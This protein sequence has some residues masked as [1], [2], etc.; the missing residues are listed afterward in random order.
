VVPSTR[1]G[2]PDVGSRGSHFEDSHSLVRSTGR[3]DARGDG[4]RGRLVI[5]QKLANDLHEPTTS[6]EQ[7]AADFVSQL[8]RMDPGISYLIS[9]IEEEPALR[10][11][12]DAR[13]FIESIEQLAG[14][15][16]GA[17]GEVSVL[18]TAVQ[19]LGEISNRLRP[20]TRRMSTVLRRISDS[21][22]T[23]QE[24]DRRLTS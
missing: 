11:E 15:A 9:Q 8:A 16:E 7:L 18:A 17:L 5:A 14:A 12:D 23:I 4:A 24:W 19:N 2:R 13:Q 1:Q 10:D 6:L 3:S 22:H 20:V 21:S